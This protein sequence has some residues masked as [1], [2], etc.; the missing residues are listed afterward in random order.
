TEDEN[1]PWKIFSDVDTLV[2]GREFTVIFTSV[3]CNI[4]RSS[5]ETV[6]QRLH[7]GEKP[8]KGVFVVPQVGLWINKKKVHGH[9][10]ITFYTGAGRDEDE[11]R[12]V[13]QTWPCELLPD[14]IF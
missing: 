9:G 10:N 8:Y 7:S 3:K 12:Y 6:V 14:W 2:C 5:T 4:I 11:D 13:L 1:V